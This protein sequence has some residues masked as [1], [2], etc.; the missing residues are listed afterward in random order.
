MKDAAAELPFGSGFA[1]HLTG[2]REMQ[3]GRYQSHLVLLDEHPVG[4]TNAAF[5]RL[6][7]LA[8][9]RFDTHA[10][11]LGLS[12]SE[13][14][15]RAHLVVFRLRRQIE[16]WLG[17]DTG[18]DWI[19]TGLATAEYRLSTP[20]G[21]IAV[22]PTF[23]ELPRALISEDLRDYLVERCPE[24]E[25]EGFSDILRQWKRNGLS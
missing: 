22:D 16:E 1:V 25:I 15:Q 13:D 18:R 5:I 20:R 4:V 21:Q 9:A 10:G 8:R 7:R 17:P 12:P 3:K 19:E 14:P 11:Y 23:R 2:H 6:A 24:V